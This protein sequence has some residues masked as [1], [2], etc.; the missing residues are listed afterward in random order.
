MLAS[1]VFS[2]KLAAPIV[3]C[4]LV[5]AFVFDLP[6]PPHAASANATA[7]NPM[8]TLVRRDDMWPPR[9][10][11]PVRQHACPAGWI[12]ALGRHPTRLRKGRDRVGFLHP[13]PLRRDAGPPRDPPFE[14]AERELRTSREYDDDERA[15]HVF[16]GVLCRIAVVDEPA[17]P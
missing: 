15:G 3:M 10:L 13:V 14:R 1:S 2:A 11:C 12:P 4:G 17:E 9:L 8:R 16:A 5:V 6:P 7:T